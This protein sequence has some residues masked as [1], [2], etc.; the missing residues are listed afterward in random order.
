VNLWLACSPTRGC[1]LLLYGNTLGRELEHYT[2]EETA[3]YRGV[4]VR[5]FSVLDSLPTH[6]I[7]P[8]QGD[9]AIFCTDHLHGSM[10][11]T[12]SHVRIAIDF[13]VTRKGTPNGRPDEFISG[14]LVHRLPQAIGPIV[15]SRNRISTRL[16]RVL[17]RIA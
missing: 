13:R 3:N 5:D 11:N 16:A 9:V 10:V 2:A 8:D 7:E 15:T 14:S 17:S 6:R 4:T 12:T 1:G